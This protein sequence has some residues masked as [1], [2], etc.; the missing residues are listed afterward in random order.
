MKTIFYFTMFITLCLISLF[1][2]GLL[3][4]ML[5][6][7]FLVIFTECKYSE[8]IQSIPFCLFT[9]IG[10]ITSSYIFND[11]LNKQQTTNIAIN[12]LIK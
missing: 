2:L 4:P 1:F 6:S 8:C 7:S 9:F 12:H 3:I 5:V 11:F 10:W